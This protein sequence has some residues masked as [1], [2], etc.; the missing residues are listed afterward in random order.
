MA[1]Q[2]HR[3]HA[4]GKCFTLQAKHGINLTKADVG[5]VFVVL[6]GDSAGKLVTHEE[7]RN[8]PVTQ[9]R[10]WDTVSELDLQ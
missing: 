8:I 2:M 3:Q 1:E 7:F 5:K 6:L 9:I 10:T 4:L